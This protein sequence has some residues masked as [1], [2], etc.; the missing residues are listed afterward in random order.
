M[1]PSPAFGSSKISGL[2]GH[3]NRDQPEKA[4]NLHEKEGKA[5][6]YNAVCLIQAYVHK[7]LGLRGQ[8]PKL[9]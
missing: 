4:D 3:N 8:S 2:P 7:G 5:N 9:C 6:R 1:T